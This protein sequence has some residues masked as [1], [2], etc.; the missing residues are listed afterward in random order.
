MINDA[1]RIII[2]NIPHLNGNG[3]FKWPP[4]LSPN[5][6]IYSARD[7]YMAFDGQQK[8]GRSLSAIIHVNPGR[9]PRAVQQASVSYMM[10]FRERRLREAINR[11]FRKSFQTCRTRSLP[12]GSRL[13]RDKVPISAVS[14]RILLAPYELVSHI[15]GR[16][17]VMRH[18]G[19][20]NIAICN[21]TSIYRKVDICDT[22]DTGYGTIGGMASSK[23][24]S[25]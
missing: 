23:Q 25:K 13:P 8:R 22:C 16:M 10:R 5:I 9:I 14:I 7:L 24:A 4:F 3:P 6:Y 19:V 20:L 12:P 1:R 17:A 15:A 2:L 18:G 21:T 11:G